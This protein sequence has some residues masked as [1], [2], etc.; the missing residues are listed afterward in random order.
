MNNI[1]MLSIDQLL[2]HPENPRFDMG[3]LDELAASIKAN[4]VMQ[5]LTVVPNPDYAGT[6]LVVIGNRRL[7]AAT[8][9]GLTELPCVISD[10]DRK[11][12]LAT[13][14]QENMHRSDLTVY[15]QAKGIQMMMDL[16]FTKEEVSEKTGFSK[17][18]IE[19][20]LSV[21]ALPDQETK[22]A[23]ECGWDLADLIEIS[24][25]EDEKMQKR[26]LVDTRKENLKHEIENAL[27]D[28]A[29]THNKQRLLPEIEKWAKPM[30]NPESRYGSSWQQNFDLTIDLDEDNAEVKVPEDADKVNYFY[31][32][33]WG[34]IR[35]YFHPKK[36][37]KE[38][39]KEEIAREKK[40]AAYEELNDRMKD[41]RI[42]FVISFSPTKKQETML[43]DK[44]FEHFLGWPNEY[45]DGDFFDNW[46]HVKEDV[47]RKL[48]DMPI[49]HT[50]DPE[51]PD[52]E[53]L[54][55]E[56]KRRGVPYGRTILALMLCGLLTDVTDG[57]YASYWSNG[58]HESKELDRAYEILIEAG[59][60][61]SEEEQKWKD[62]THPIYG[63][64][65]KK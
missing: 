46:P 56:C 50:H 19:R 59:Y 3:D 28:Q 27:R 52:K 65:K 31:V 29:R 24:K 12:Q 16:G 63:K 55:A 62:G 22:D 57:G 18:T 60:E 8:I 40:Q 17:A 4:G 48:L 44:F 47:F 9:A 38:K 7:E 42:A 64:G 14:L 20:R 36:E 30:K 25:V 10:M 61:L 39:T 49:D 13:M 26:L 11:A 23:V 33:E 43:K 45:R 34:A 21:A 37:K 51:N 54:L 5:N 15:E 58:H 53:S 6:Y 32:I 35:F 41:R 1:V 2:H